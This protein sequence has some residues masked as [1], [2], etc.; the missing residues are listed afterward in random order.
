MIGYNQVVHLL[1]SIYKSE[2]AFSLDYLIITNHSNDLCSFFLTLS[3]PQSSP[4]KTTPLQ[5][6]QTALNTRL[7]N[8][9]ENQKTHLTIKLIEIRHSTHDK[10][11]R[12]PHLCSIGIQLNHARNIIYAAVI[13]TSFKSLIKV[14]FFSNYKIKMRRLARWCSG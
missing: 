4:D 8:S 10:V 3:T 14:I 12:H 13:S 9:F 6:I 2:N 11:T 7:E 5:R 1:E